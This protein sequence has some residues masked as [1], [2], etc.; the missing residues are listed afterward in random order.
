MDFIDKILDGS[1]AAGGT[2]LIIGVLCVV[3]LILSVVLGGIFEAF[4][5]GEGGPLSLT[6]IAAFGS[7][8]GFVGYASIGGG[9]SVQIATLLGALT[10]VT[11]GFL[12]FIA[13]RFLS[14]SDSTGSI[15]ATSLAGSEAIVILR[16]PGG[17]NLG[18][19]ALTRNG[20]RY[21]F[22]AISKLPISTGSKVNIVSTI[23]NSSVFVEEIINSK[24]TGDENGNGDT[25]NTSSNS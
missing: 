25:V 22:S 14:N 7:V 19:V 16:I 21:T 9:A 6:T 13:M 4:H 24:K 20:L 17:E 5:F 11:G 3:L 23:S 1:I 8:F 18:E 10:G 15:E 2:F 12:S